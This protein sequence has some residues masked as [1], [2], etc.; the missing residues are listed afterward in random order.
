M[1]IVQLFVVGFLLFLS[2]NCRATSNLV[3]CGF[4]RDQMVFE[5]PNGTQ[6][7]VSEILWLR[8]SRLEIP[9]FSI[10]SCRTSDRLKARKYVDLLHGGLAARVNALLIV[11]DGNPALAY[12]TNGE[13]ENIII[14]EPSFF[15]LPPTYSM[16]MQQGK[17]DIRTFW[18]ADGTVSA[19][20]F[21]V[22]S[23]MYRVNKQAVDILYGRYSLEYDKD[24]R[25]VFYMYNDTFSSI[26]I[27]RRERLE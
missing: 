13:L 20:I 27:L 26:P 15:L 17:F 7:H 8:E 3:D 5:L 22:S 9:P 1:T 16:V 11:K 6:L 14:C 21:T 24:E 19:P 23:F 25:L 12:L 18:F 10:D 4:S 2:I